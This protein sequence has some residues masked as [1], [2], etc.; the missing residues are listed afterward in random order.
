[1]EEGEMVEDKLIIPEEFKNYLNQVA[2]HELG[3]VNTNPT[4]PVNV[5]TNTNATSSANANTNAG[6]NGNTNGTG[7]DEKS[8]EQAQMPP[9]TQRRINSNAENFNQ[10]RNPQAYQM[11]SPLNQPNSPPLV[12]TP[13]TT[14]ATHNGDMW[15][16]SQYQQAPP[17]YPNYYNQMGH[18]PSNNT[19][20]TPMQYNNY[21]G[22]SNAMN[23][24]MM[25]YGAYS[26]ISN[27]F[28]IGLFGNISIK[29]Q[30]N[31]IIKNF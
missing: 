1:M 10:W 14:P 5:N 11:P 6:V 29:N 25:N 18:S 3:T 30:K 24:G 13:N 19:T 16:C 21:N 2:D 15:P 23:Y 27:S 22:Y 17:P 8:T 7:S 12:A 26:F 9:Q 4:N 28:F 31:S 20:T